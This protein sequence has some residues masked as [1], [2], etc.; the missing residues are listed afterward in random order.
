LIRIFAPRFDRLSVSR[1]RAPD[2]FSIDETTRIS[3]LKLR[4]SAYHVALPDGQ[5]GIDR[6]S[7]YA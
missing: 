3:S 6:S 1:T 2:E 7:L 4:L 5:L